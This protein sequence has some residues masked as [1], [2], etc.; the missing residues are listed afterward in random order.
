MLDEFFW[1]ELPARLD[2]PG[3][4]ERLLFERSDPL[5]EPDDSRIFEELEALEISD[6]LAIGELGEVGEEELTRAAVMIF[7]A[8]RDRV[9]GGVGIQIIAHAAGD[10]DPFGRVIERSKR[11][12]DM[13][14]LIER[15]EVD[16]ILFARSVVR[17]EEALVDGPLTELRDSSAD[18][19]TIL[20]RERSDL[21]PATIRESCDIGFED[22]PHDW[23]M[24][25][26]VRLASSNLRVRPR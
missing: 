3:L 20:R 10:A 15:G 17:G 26:C 7:V 18:R 23:I 8:D 19:V 21:H 2:D 25:R 9:F 5:C 11:E 4:D 22:G 13:L 1:E 14:M 12:R 24:T 6:A 16:E